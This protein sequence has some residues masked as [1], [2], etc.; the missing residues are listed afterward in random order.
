MLNVL[1]NLNWLS[2]IAAAI[3]YFMLGALWFAPLTFGRFYDRGLGFVR[4]PNWRPGAEYYIGPFVG[5]LM[6]AIAT[7]VLLRAASCSSL[8]DAIALGLVVGVGVAG[9]VSGV[10]AITPI[11]PRPF[12]FG[13]ITGLYHTVGITAVAI[14]E[15]LWR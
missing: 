6:A 4:P 3:A 8:H 1:S 9:A 14:I 7:S 2:T 13:A 12:L 11:T 15:Y 10:N 5:C